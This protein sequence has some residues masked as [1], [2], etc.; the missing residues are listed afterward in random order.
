MVFTDAELKYIRDSVKR[1]ADSSVESVSRFMDAEQ[2]ESYKSQVAE[3][4]TEMLLRFIEDSHEDTLKVLSFWFLPPIVL[5]NYQFV[6]DGIV[7]REQKPLKKR[8]IRI[9]E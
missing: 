3:T 7:L 6:T 4:W 9:L 5:G 1:R 2:I 8:M